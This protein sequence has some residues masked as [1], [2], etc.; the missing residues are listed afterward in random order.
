MG[1]PWGS[2]LATSFQLLHLKFTTPRGCR[3]IGTN[4]RF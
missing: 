4:F 3:I 1:L 2:F